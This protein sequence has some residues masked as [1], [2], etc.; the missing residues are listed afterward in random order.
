MALSEETRRIRF[1]TCKRNAEKL[2]Q[3][4]PRLQANAQAFLQHHK[5]L[6]DWTVEY[7]AIAPV[8]PPA[9]AEQLRYSGVIAGS[10]DILLNPLR[11]GSARHG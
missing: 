7:C 3:S 5:S 6:S 9:E 10:L 4:V 8:I 1:G 11:P 2:L